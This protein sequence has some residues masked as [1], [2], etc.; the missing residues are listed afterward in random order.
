MTTTTAAPPD[1]PAIADR[2]EQEAL[3]AGVALA[4]IRE[5]AHPS[6]GDEEL[7]A[8]WDDFTE[9]VRV[10]EALG[11]GEMGWQEYA[12]DLTCPGRQETA[13]QMACEAADEAR[14]VIQHGRGGF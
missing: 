4:A 1:G 11:T 5:Y 3:F 2:I 7:A 8:A 13:F 6:L 14:E 9:A 12:P 10:R